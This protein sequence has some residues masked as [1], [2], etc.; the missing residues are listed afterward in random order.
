MNA[1]SLK[2]ISLFCRVISL[3]AVVMAL[4]AIAARFTGFQA[5]K[6]VLSYGPPDALFLRVMG[7]GV[8][9]DPNDFAQFLLIGLAF[10]GVAW[11]KGNPIRNLTSVLIPGSILIFTIYLTGSRGAIFGLAA[12][13][14]TM[15]SRRKGLKKA[16][17]LTG[18]MFALFI[19]AGFGRGGDI[20]LHEGS[21]AG[22]VMAWGSGISQLRTNPLFGVGF[23]RFTEYNDLTAHNSFVLCFAE[24]GFF[25]YF[26]WIALIVTSVLGLEAMNKIPVVTPDDADFSR[27]LNA[28]RAGLYTFLATAWFL[29]RTYQQTLYIILALAAVLICLRRTQFPEIDLP[30]VNWAPRAVLVSVFSVVAIYVTIRLRAF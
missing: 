25:G 13:A 3:C 15:F 27:C 22:R 11:R 14:F 19:I 12:I 10:L 17:I 29:S 4:E 2:R 8:L 26:P 30:V 24:N 18:G 20:S 1:Y 21:A 28:V 5:D 23:N 6:L 9:S 7:Y 16:A